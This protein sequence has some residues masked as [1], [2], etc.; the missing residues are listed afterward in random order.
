MLISSAPED[1]ELCNSAGAGSS[2]T[3]MRIIQKDP[4]IKVIDSVNFFAQGRVRRTRSM[5]FLDKIQD[6]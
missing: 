2:I 4:K 3:S 5:P 1:K 6:L